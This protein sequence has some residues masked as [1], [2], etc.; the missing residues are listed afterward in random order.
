[1]IY[2]NF[3]YFIVA[4]MM[5]SMAPDGPNQFFSLTQDVVFIAIIYLLFYQ[6]NKQRFLR[7]R[8]QFAAERISIGQA[9]QLFSSYINFNLFV[10]IFLFAIQV[11]LFDLRTLI[12]QIPI[13]GK[14]ETSINGLGL[15][16]FLLHLIVVW[17]WAYRGMGDVFQPGSDAWSYAWSQVKFN[18]VI[19]LPWILLSLVIDALDYFPIPVSEQFLHSGL[20]HLLLFVLFLLVLAVFAPVL[21]VRLWDCE[22]FPQTELRDKI[23]GFCR[24]Q[25]V[26]FRGVYSWNAMN[27]GLVTAGVVGLIAPFRYLLITPGLLNILDDDEVLAVVS[28]EVGHVK[29]KHM[30][31]YILFFLSFVVLV[32]SA[33]YHLLKLV[34]N[35]NFGLELLLESGSGFLNTFVSLFS[36]L[37]FILSFVL[38][39]RFVFGFFMRNFERQADLYCFESGI[40]PHHMISSFNKLGRIVGDDGSRTNWHHFNIPQRIEFLR[41][42][43]A[44]PEKI[45]EHRQTLQRGLVVFLVV[46]VVFSVIAFRPQYASLENAMDLSRMAEVLETKVTKNPNNSDLFRM[47][48][49]LYYQTEKWLQAKLAYER[50]LEID[51]RQP[52]VLNNLAWLLI[53]CPENSIRDYDMALKLASRAIVL[54]PEA[55]IFDT[56]G[57]AFFENGKYKE[58]YLSAAKALALAREN[59]QYYRDQLKKMKK[60]YLSFRDTIKI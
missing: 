43:M 55:H 47:L 25:G 46:M 31:F 12:L 4:I 41:D 19:V 6:Y 1:M 2:Q 51:H 39:V 30:F 14:F 32:Y 11:F 17:Y 26:K 18:L 53:K 8:T 38:Y 7:L 42:A 52:E 3:L 58:A 10:A 33:L 36:L 13:A 24:A 27:K 48:G 15:S 49:E 57:E 34:L 9:K 23:V 60:A 35:S 50:S 40:D 21:M 45:A 44:R 29:K 22:P 54:K 59:R 5:F 16:F 28:H 20:S 37:V 56:L